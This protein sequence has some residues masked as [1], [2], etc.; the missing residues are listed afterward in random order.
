MKCFLQSQIPG[1]GILSKMKEANVPLYWRSVP[2]KPE[3]LQEGHTYNGEASQN[4]TMRVTCD[5][6]WN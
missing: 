1:R 3:H 6:W 2:N 4:L 5:G